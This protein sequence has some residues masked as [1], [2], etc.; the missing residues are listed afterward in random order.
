MGEGAVIGCLATT[1]PL[2]PPPGLASKSAYREKQGCRCWVSVAI[3]WTPGFHQLNQY[4]DSSRLIVQL[5][6]GKT[7]GSRESPSTTTEGE[8]APERVMQ[9]QH[10]YLLLERT[11]ESHLGRCLSVK[12]H[13]RLGCMQLLINHIYKGESKRRPTPEKRLPHPCF[14]RNRDYFPLIF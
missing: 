13:Q 1:L 14:L 5:H 10:S 7:E 4:L 12:F 2:L 8:N 3:P 6:F 9:K 11:G